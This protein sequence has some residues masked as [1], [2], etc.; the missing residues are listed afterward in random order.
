MSA[1]IRIALLVLLSAA[2]LSG[3][4]DQETPPS[5][6]DDDAA[7]PEAPPT[8]D[9]SERERTDAAGADA[10]SSPY[11]WQ[12]SLAELRE[13]GRLDELP[14][15]EVTV[16][17]D[18][19]YGSEKR[20]RGWPLDELLALAGDLDASGDRDVVLQFVATDGYRANL[21][22]DELPEGAGV[23]AF[24]DRDA[25]EGEQWAP[26][27]HGDETTTPAPFYLVWPNRRHAD[28]ELPWA[29]KLA[30]I[31]AARYRDLWGDA[32]PAHDPDARSGFALFRQNCIK[33][34]SVNRSGGAVGPELNVPMNVT[35]YWKPDHLRR[36]IRDAPSYRA[37]TAMP[38]FESLTDRQV[39]QLVGYLR[40]MAAAKVCTSTSECRQID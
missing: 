24:E 25:P 14:V 38:S 8:A 16:P 6:G 27:E 15:V 35:E 37:G 21:P 7:S 29:Y 18:P 19:A 13:S 12:I 1:P 17:D 9:A 30:E 23:I 33:C 28:A 22:L 5:Q 2:P 20:Y 34:H 26:F 36:Y 39:G 31:A 4:D 40:S 10:A 3:C 32:Y 11:L